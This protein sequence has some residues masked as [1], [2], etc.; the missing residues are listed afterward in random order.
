[1]EGLN[2]WGYGYKTQHSYPRSWLITWRRPGVKFG[3]NVMKKK[4]HKNYQDTDKKS[5]INKK[6]ILRLRS[7]ILKWFQLKTNLSSFVC[8]QL[9]SFKN[10]NII[11][12]ILFNIISLFALS[13]IVPS[14][15][16]KLMTANECL[17]KLLMLNWNTWNRLT[18]CKNWIISTTLG[19]YVIK[20]KKTKSKESQLLQVVNNQ[21]F[22]L[23]DQALLSVQI[24]MSLSDHQNKIGRLFQG[25]SSDTSGHCVYCAIL[26]AR[27]FWPYSC[28]FV[29]CRVQDLFNTAR[30]LHV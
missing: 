24:E 28:C 3:R 13:Q 29:G 7:L 5:A 19:W 2:Y 8:T 11:L 15:S 6:L 4:Q 10:C 21:N 18:V 14:F 16:R 25:L 17:I 22:I 20:A 23:K 1:M 26:Q 12:I 9:N 30:S 27:D